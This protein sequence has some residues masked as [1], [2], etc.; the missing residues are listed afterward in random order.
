HNRAVK[1]NTVGPLQVALGPPTLGIRRRRIDRNRNCPE[2]RQELSGI[3]PRRLS[4][5]SPQS[6]LL[7]S[8]TRTNPPMQNGPS[9]IFALTYAF[10][11]ALRRLKSL[12]F[13][14]KRCGNR[15]LLEFR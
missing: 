2:A 15:K 6:G 4:I 3:Y 5:P 1:A 7:I 11:W 14:R 10:A 13:S 9:Q 8:R 12:P